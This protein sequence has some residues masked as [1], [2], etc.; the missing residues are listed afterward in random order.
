MELWCKNE[1]KRIGV[2]KTN[3][4]GPIHMKFS[5]FSCIPKSWKFDFIHLIQSMKSHSSRIPKEKYVFWIRKIHLSDFEIPITVIHNSPSMQVRCR[6]GRLPLHYCTVG[7]RLENMR[8][9]LNNLTKGAS[10]LSQVGSFE[11][12]HELKISMLSLPKR[13]LLL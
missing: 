13:V 3:E 4:Q 10:G 11:V 9:L 5:C 8:L 7:D 2:L 12:K 6:Q 1:L